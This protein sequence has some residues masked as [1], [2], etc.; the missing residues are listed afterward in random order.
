MATSEVAESL[1]VV[2][3]YHILRANG[4]RNR[5]NLLEKTLS[6]TVLENRSE[7]YGCTLTSHTLFQYDVQNSFRDWSNNQHFER[8][9]S[10][11]LIHPGIAQVCIPQLVDSVKSNHSRCTTFGMAN[12]VNVPNF[13]KEF[14]PGLWMCRH[15]MVLKI[16]LNFKVPERAGCLSGNRGRLSSG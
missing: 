15:S 6:D 5:F 9:H 12:M 1:K 14:R 10:L 11:N 4:I 3:D 7:M 13:N 8:F 16:G 2:A